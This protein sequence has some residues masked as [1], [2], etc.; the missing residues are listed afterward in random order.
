[1]K[2]GARDF[3]S[4][5]YDWG[6]PEWVVLAIEAPVDKVRKA[7]GRLH[8]PT[9]EFCGV[10]IRLA[11]KKDTEIAPLVA[12]VKPKN[13]SWTVILR[14]LC[15]PIDERDIT[16]AA[17]DAQKLSL[18]L[19]TRGLTFFGEDISDLWVYRHGKK[20]EEKEWGQAKSADKAFEAFGLYLP[21]CYPC[22]RD[23][24]PW[25]AAK[26]S[27]VNHIETA[28][29]I[30]LEAVVT[31]L[32]KA[33]KQLAAD[34][35]RAARA[36]NVERIKKL[37]AAGAP[38]NQSDDWDGFRPLISAAS[39]GHLAAVKALLAAGADVNLP[40]EAA[41]DA[42]WQG[43][44]ALGVACHRGHTGMVK[45]LLK[46]GAKVKFDREEF[47]TAIQYAV[48]KGRLE[49]VRTLLQAGATLT[50]PAVSRAVR[51]AMLKGNTTILKE[52]LKNKRRDEIPFTPQTASCAIA[53]D[54][55]PVQRQTD[56][57]KVLLSAG[58][59]VNGGDWEAMKNVIRQGNVELLKFLIEAGAEVNPRGKSSSTPLHYAAYLNWLDGAKV[60]V[61]SGARL[62][63]KNWE[64]K[65]PLEWAKFQGSKEV[66]RFLEEKRSDK[67]QDKGK[68]VV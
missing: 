49:I 9:E 7:Y 6:H 20:A 67:V 21:A 37:V 26:N 29:I 45:E 61:T 60:L 36:G 24:G 41:I 57:L 31:K 5:I 13:S 66:A 27:S 38:V 32:S 65:T 52:L 3:V 25:V 46:A 40:V 8:A 10:P 12:I 28:D 1:M 11:E 55:W 18:K 14:L 53:T 16:E 64:G 34:L 17:E 48:E 30:N 22:R 33:A 39:K 59:D 63:A 54:R 56:V 2:T 15:L 19:R 68:G 35:N 58:A 44:T 47:G 50:R 51:W 43:A 23:G 4:F 42:D 62:D